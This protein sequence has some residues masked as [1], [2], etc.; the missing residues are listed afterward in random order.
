M[1]FQEKLR[2]LLNPSLFK[3]LLFAPLLI[4]CAV[5][6]VW[7]LVSVAKGGNTVSQGSTGGNMAVMDRYDMA[8]TNRLSASMEGILAIDKVYWLR[9]E[10]V[11]AP[12]PNQKLFGQTRDP[13]DIAPVLEAA[14]ELLGGQEVLFSENKNFIPD[15]LIRYY[16]DDTILVLVWQEQFRGSIYTIS[17]IKL[18]HPSQFRR[19]F[20]GNEYG[21]NKQYLSTEMSAEVNAVMASSGDFYMYRSDGL[22]V[23]NGVVERV[24]RSWGVET[25]FIDDKGDMSFCHIGQL[26]NKEEAQK[27]VDEHNIRFSISFGPILVENGVKKYHDWYLLGEDNHKDLQNFVKD[28]LHT[29]RKYPALYAGDTDPEGFEWINAD[30]ADRSIFSYVRK[31][32][33]GRNNVLVVMNFT[34]I[35]RPD[36][37]VGVPKK[38]QYRLLMT[39][40]GLTE[41]K[42]VYK[43]EESECD[44]HPYSFAYPLPAYGVAMFLY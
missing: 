21:H 18:A 14:Q 20:A 41:T 26:M 40:K 44:N 9:D 31:S 37:R 29:Y 25:C 34:P 1:K 24:D 16:L 28:L 5:S 2:A 4:L 22:V 23:Y 17:E 32:A 8:I 12:E 43:A 30:D 7:T 36:Y 33:T 13:K 10:D 39:E 38:K 15:S 42:E 27:Y 6:I 11:I 35:D 3:K 19:F